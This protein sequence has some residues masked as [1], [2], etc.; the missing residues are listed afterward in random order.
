MHRE[1]GVPWTRGRLPPN[2][3]PENIRHCYL[4]TR[5][6]ELYVKEV[7]KW[8][9][10]VDHRE[11]GPDRTWRWTKKGEGKTSIQA[12]DEVNFG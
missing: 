2:Q 10:G 9:L 8:T 4:F 1:G 3:V 11:G 7:A 5:V 6:L 12:H